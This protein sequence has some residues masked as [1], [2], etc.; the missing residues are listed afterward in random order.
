MEKKAKNKQ[1]HLSIECEKTIQHISQL[2][3]ELVLRQKKEM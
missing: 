3:N 1:K 2:S